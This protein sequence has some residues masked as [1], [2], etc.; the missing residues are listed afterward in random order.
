M[1][2]GTVG[3]DEVRLFEAKVEGFFQPDPGH[4]VFA[5]KGGNYHGVPESELGE[6]DRKVFVDRPIENSGT[7]RKGKIVRCGVFSWPDK[8]QLVLNSIVLVAEEKQ[9]VFL[10]VRFVKDYESTGG[11]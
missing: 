4:A 9:A 2:E 3:L 11:L 8:R 1:G 6:H 7:V 5:V 10:F